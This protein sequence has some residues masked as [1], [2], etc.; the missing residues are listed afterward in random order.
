[1]MALLIFS[2]YDMTCSLSSKKG[3]Q[4][5]LSLFYARIR[6][7][8]FKYNISCCTP[9]RA[10]NNDPLLTQTFPYVNNIYQ[11]DNPVGVG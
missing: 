9:C 5:M 2:I 11:T 10:S 3:F 6:F 1:M 7:D 4:A 8:V